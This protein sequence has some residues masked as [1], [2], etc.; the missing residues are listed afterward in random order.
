V[1][2]IQIKVASSVGLRPKRSPES[3]RPLGPRW[4]IRFV[5]GIAAKNSHFLLFSI[6]KHAL[7]P[8]HSP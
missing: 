4:L 1:L 8:S 3:K 7:T 2:P 6:K 5:I